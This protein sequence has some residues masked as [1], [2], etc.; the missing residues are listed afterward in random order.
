M[1]AGNHIREACK[2]KWMEIRMPCPCPLPFRTFAAAYPKLM[3]APIA[4]QIPRTA[5]NGRMGKFVAE[6]FYAQISMCI[7]VNDREIGV[8]LCRSFDCGEADQM[9][10]ADQKGQLSAVQDR[11]CALSNHR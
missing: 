5:D 9:L 4:E 11:L 1:E 2:G 6:I 3:D 7:E 10:P 8:P